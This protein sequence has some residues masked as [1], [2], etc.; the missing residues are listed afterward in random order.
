MFHVNAGATAEEFMALRE[1]LF[2]D[3]F[4]A[5][6]RPVVHGQAAAEIVAAS[7]LLGLLRGYGGGSS[8]G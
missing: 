8:V 2:Q 3:A 1:V 5:V 7:R 6:G 4:S